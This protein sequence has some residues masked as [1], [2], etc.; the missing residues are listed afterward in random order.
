MID[1]LA[2]LTNFVP[3]YRVG[4]YRRIAE[5]AGKLS[6]YCSTQMETDRPWPVAHA[7]LDVIVQRTVSI[8][9]RFAH[10]NGFVGHTTVHIPIDTVPLLLAGRPDVVISNELGTRSIQ[11]ALYSSISQRTGLVL[12]ATVSESSEAGRGAG[13]RLLRHVLLRRADAVIVNGNSG[14]RYV[15]R[16]GVE[17]ERIFIAPYSIDYGMF[18][19]QGTTAK[20]AS[21]I[22]ILFV[23]SS[24]REKGWTVLSVSCQ[25][26]ASTIH[27]S[28]S[29]WR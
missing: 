24:Y 27:V 5:S 29:T 3:P 19:A 16:F 12:W 28:W 20:V 15:S 1:R 26:G 6:I 9:R 21:T 7:D 14:M 25:S 23:G 17:K 4:L 10:P 13:R 8:R 11:S 18:S 2:I 22:R